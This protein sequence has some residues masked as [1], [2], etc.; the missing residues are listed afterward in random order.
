MNRK[1]FILSALFVFASVSAFAQSAS[2][3]FKPFTSFRVIQTEHFDIIF[4]KESEETARTL[5]SYADRVYDQI[6]SLLGI[7]VRGRI[8]VTITPHTDL[9]NGYYSDFFNHIMLF[10]T[11][12]DVEWTNFHNNLQ[13]LFLHELTHAVSFNTRSPSNDRWYRVFG[14]IYTP[15]IMNA[16]LFMV[17]GVTLSFESLDGGGRANDPRTK[18]YLRQ[19]VHENKFLTPFQASGVYDKQIRPNGYW[20]EYGGLFSAWLQQNYGMEKYAELWK[21]MG[22]DGK[23]SF[24]KYRSGFY[25]IFK[26]VYDV[27]FLDEWKKFGD[28]F[29][30]DG[31]ET[32]ENELSS[33]KYSYFSEREYFVRGL[34]ARNNNLYFIETSEAKIGVYDTLTGKTKTFNA[35]SGIYDIDVSADGKRMLLSGYRYVED[36]AFAYVCEYKTNNGWKT[37]GTINGLGK[38]RYFRDGVIGIRSVLHNNRIVFEKFDGKSEILFTGNETLMFSGPQALD[39]ERIVFIAMREGKRELWI[40]NYVTKELF[41]IENTQGDNEYWTYMR[42]LN[43]SDGKIYFGY[44]SD[45]RMYKLAQID[46]ETMQAVFSGRDFSGGVFN[47][48]SADGNVY[49]LATFV[50]RNSLMRFPETADSLSGNKIHLRLTK[51]DNQNY[52][53]ASEPPYTGPSKPYI[54]LPYMNPFKFWTPFILPILT[55][56]DE[57]YSWKIYCFILSAMQDPLDMNSIIFMANA[58]FYQ[59]MAE[60]YQFRWQNTAMGFPVTLNITDT[61]NFTNLTE[62]NDNMRRDTNVSLTAGINWSGNQWNN[63]ISFGGGYYRTADYEDGKSAY[64]W[65]KNES[66]FFAQTGFSFS[67]R[68]ASLQFSGASPISSFVP[69]LDMVFR[70]SAKTR[71]PLS[72]TLFGAYDKNGMD[73]HGLSNFFSKTIIDQFVLKEYK[74]QSGLELSWLGGGEVSL[75]LFSLEIQKHLSHVYYNRFSGS[76]SVRNQIYDS[77]GHPDAEG[78]K[79]NSLHLVQSLGLKM[80]LKISFLPLAVL[81]VSLEPFVLGTWN[82]SNT[83]AGKGGLWA[84]TIGLSGLF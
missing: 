23:F 9:F 49:Y 50:S 20:Y 25:G 83:I 22:D 84:V 48:V 42:D 72:L 66:G 52:R 33:K 12:M 71:F 27:D 54:G 64:E 1:I 38:A 75:G 28:S 60:I 3:Q 51:L 61:L 78:I 57:N 58:N 10:D 56:D 69:R 79:I 43:V 32:N 16:P 15:A 65:G 7:E 35:D 40:F 17:E 24:F 81:P 13:K 30:L 59:K 70:V 46:L 53:I 62:S 63:Q 73:T 11:P 21:E 44:N 47:P 34:T 74:N 45:D 8:P 41:K 29:A 31:L 5:A 26:K 76:L 2:A 77:G 55:A 6:S 36:R 68:R 82:F 18:Q 19:A 4:P 67:Y 14:T 37:G 39:D 80:G